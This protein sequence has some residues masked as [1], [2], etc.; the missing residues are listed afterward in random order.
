MY[1]DTLPILF[2]DEFIVA[3]NKPAGLL[4]HRGAATSLSEA[5][6][7]QRLRDQLK[8]RVY[9]VHRLDRATSGVL[10]LAKTSAAAAY[11]GRQFSAH[12][13]E[14]K[15]LAVLR[16]WPEPLLRIDHPIKDEDQVQRPAQ[17]AVTHLEL[18][19]AT[20]LDRALD[21][22]PKT[23]YSL[24]SLRPE[25]GRRH[26]LR[27]HCKSIFHPILGDTKYGHGIHN[28]FFREELGVARL[29]LH[30][31]SLQFLHPLDEKSMLIRAPL[32]IQFKNV[33]N[34]FAWSEPQI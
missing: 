1:L 24:V 28:R 6:V 34:F 22:Y 26:Q 2:E 13:L 19:A 17:S 25:T 3:V 10:L 18:L 5:A 33:L 30:H 7:V 11:L 16:G 15:Y 4:V 23:R 14:K 32:D 27:R 12:S 9:P 31:D 8:H 21:R 20:E 29:L